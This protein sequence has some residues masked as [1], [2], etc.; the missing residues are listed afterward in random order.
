MLT[1]AAP[2]IDM[3]RPETFAILQ[4]ML[5]DS[6]SKVSRT[7][8]S[9]MQQFNDTFYDLTYGSG[10]DRECTADAVSF[11]LE[12]GFMT[13]IAEGLDAAAAGRD[14]LLLSPSSCNTT[15]TLRAVECLNK[16]AIL[17]DTVEYLA[18]DRRAVSYML[19]KAAKAT[20]HA[21]ANS[22]RR[23]NI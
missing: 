21:Q 22:A 7:R 15:K 8:F 16:P 13:P 2:A 12:R 4:S 17:A 20:L 19:K 18:V 9:A 3:R 14:R 1:E 6:N 10:K 11:L 23:A 5:K